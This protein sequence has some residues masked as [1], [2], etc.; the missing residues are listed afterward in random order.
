MSAVDRLEFLVGI[1]AVPARHV[2]GELCPVER[3]LLRGRH[4]VLWEPDPALHVA[5]RI[6]NEGACR[7]GHEA[8]RRGGGPPLL[9]PLADGIDCLVVNQANVYRREGRKLDTGVGAGN[10]AGV[11]PREECFWLPVELRNR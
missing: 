6:T 9:V 5:I 1:E 10:G 4:N 3:P 7:G 11:D 8:T 2:A